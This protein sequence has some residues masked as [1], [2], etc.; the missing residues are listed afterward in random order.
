MNYQRILT[1]AGVVLA[2]LL[3]SYLDRKLNPQEWVD[4]DKEWKRLK[5]YIKKKVSR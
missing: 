4:F 1:S 3:F 5:N 2:V